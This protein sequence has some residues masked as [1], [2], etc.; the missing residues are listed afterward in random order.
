MSCPGKGDIMADSLKGSQKAGHKG[1]PADERLFTVPLR[2]EFLKVPSNKRAKRSVSTIRSHLSRHMKAPESDVKLSG[3]LNDAIWTRG[4]AKPPGKIRIKAS[5][6]ASTGHLNAMLPDEKPPEKDKKGK[7]KDAGKAADKAA[8]TEEVKKAVDKA[9]SEKKAAAEGKGPP[10][11]SGEAGRD[12]SGHVR[13]DWLLLP[14]HRKAGQ[15]RKDIC[16]REEPLIIQLP[17][18]EHQ[19]EPRAGEDDS[20]PRGLHGSKYGKGR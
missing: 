14:A 9:V 4:A 10:A 15:A 11:R 6:D 13:R 17:E 7:S 19:A 16:H 1:S 18:G 8:I 20:H 5:F 3:K 2:K 12:H